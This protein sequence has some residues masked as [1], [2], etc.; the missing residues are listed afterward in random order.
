MVA[1]T[2]AKLHKWIDASLANDQIEKGI[3]S[4][5][6]V[7]KRTTLNAEYMTSAT[8]REQADA[9]VDYRET[10]SARNIGM[11]SPLTTQVKQAR[12]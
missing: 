2:G 11:F 12:L 4:E 9:T 7:E 5:V 3:G 10:G 1:A 6:D 8:P